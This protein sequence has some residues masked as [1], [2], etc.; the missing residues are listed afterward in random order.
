MTPGEQAAVR[1]LTLN[2]EQQKGIPYTD[3]E[4]AEIERLNLEEAD[5]VRRRYDGEEFN[6][7]LCQQYI[8]KERVVI[9]RRARR[10]AMA[11]EPHPHP[12]DRPG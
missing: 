2:R 5:A 11:E 3:E 12:T 8:A 4:R 1:V 9:S 6:L 7:V 10:R